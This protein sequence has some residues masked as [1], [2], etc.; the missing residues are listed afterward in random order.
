M[1]HSLWR[2]KQAE[3][4]KVKLQKEGIM[5]KEQSRLELIKK[6]FSHDEA[7][8]QITQLIACDDQ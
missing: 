3:D 6:E 2:E 1:P 4:K 5:V 8:K 7:L